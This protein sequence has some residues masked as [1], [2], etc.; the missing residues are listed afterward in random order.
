[1]CVLIL[2][3]PPKVVSDVEL[4]TAGCSGTRAKLKSGDELD[5]GWLPRKVDATLITGKLN[6]SCKTSDLGENLI[7]ERDAI[8]MVAEALL[9]GNGIPLLPGSGNFDV[10]FGK[11]SRDGRSSSLFS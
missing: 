7:A 10:L 4:A 5:E 8:G 1:M 6:L 11:F 9:A 2:P 3:G